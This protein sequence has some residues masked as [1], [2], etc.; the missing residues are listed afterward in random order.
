MVTLDRVSRHIEREL[1]TVTREFAAPPFSALP[2]RYRNA[3]AAFL[4]RK[5]KR[6]RPALFVLSYLSYA[7]RPAPHV[8]RSAV[9][10]ELLHDFALIHDDII[11]H[12]KERRRGPA[13]HIV[14]GRKR[15]G[16]SG[17]KFTGENMAMVAGDL[18]Y[19]LGV[20][21]FL[22]ADVTA[23]RKLAALDCLTQY[24]VCTACGQL[25][26]LLETAEPLG[27]LTARRIAETCQLKTAYYSFACP[28]A[29]G[30]LMGG[31]PASDR[32]ALFRYGLSLGLAYQIQ[33]DLAELTNGHG[34]NAFAD[35]RDGTRTLPL[36]YA[37]NHAS[38]GDRTR[39]ANAVDGGKR[40]LQ[41]LR[42][43]RDIIVRAG[44]VAYAMREAQRRV[45]EGRRILDSLSM[46]R[47]GRES[48]WRY[49]AG[50]LDDP[51]M[52]TIESG[53]AMRTARETARGLRARTRENDVEALPRKIE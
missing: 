23:E 5:G 39:L 25:K 1:R 19:A 50:L 7:A 40:S 18:M 44:G 9:G 24:A 27:R 8:Y 49:T 37:F 22:S 13:L 6:L 20:R 31:A 12:S 10:L 4:L 3:I 36:W 34:R 28:L 11:D 26:E 17:L 46:D 14:L 2:A 21:L 52:A 30:A 16:H 42:A 41:D 45:E 47:A 29:T 33:D 15:N 48:L 38:R 43:A 32:D 53:S 35:L 51:D